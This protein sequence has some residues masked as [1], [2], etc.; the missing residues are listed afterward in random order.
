MDFPPISNLTQ[1]IGACGMVIPLADSEDAVAFYTRNGETF[2]LIKSPSG[3]VWRNITDQ[4]ET[5]AR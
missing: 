2:T 1:S 3:A 5:G 4:L